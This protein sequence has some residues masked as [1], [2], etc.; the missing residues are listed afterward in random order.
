VKRLVNLIPLSVMAAMF[1]F[2]SVAGAQDGVPDQYADQYALGQGVQQF[3]ADPYALEQGIP[4]QQQ[5]EQ[6]APEQQEEQVAPEPV[7]PEGCGAEE[8]TG[9]GDFRMSTVTIKPFGGGDVPTYVAPGTTVRWVNGDTI[10]HT[11]TADDGSFDSGVLNPGDYAM[12]TFLGSGTMTYHCEIHPDTMMGSVTVGE[13][14]GEGTASSEQYSAGD[15]GS[16]Y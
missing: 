8:N 3:A 9:G 7:A 5:E 10:P 11:V 16:G 13:G 4:E 12:V 2:A 15:T 1:W 14:N 6:V